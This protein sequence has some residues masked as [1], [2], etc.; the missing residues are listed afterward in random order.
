MHTMII[1]LQQ[2]KN[3]WRLPLEYRMAEMFGGGKVW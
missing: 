1:V 3:N 2:L